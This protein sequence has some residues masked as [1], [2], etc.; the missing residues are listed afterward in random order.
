MDFGPSFYRLPS[1]ILG[2]PAAATAIGLI[3]MFAALGG[4][5]GSTVIGKMFQTGY[6]FPRVIEFLSTCFCLAGA[7]C[8]CF[9]RRL[10]DPLTDETP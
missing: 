3:N 2:E 5:V 7:L 6:S 10:R 4:F 1:L 8:F 9:R